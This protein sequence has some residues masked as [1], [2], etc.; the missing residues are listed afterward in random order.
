[1]EFHGHLFGAFYFKDARWRLIKINL[2]IGGILGDEYLTMPGKIYR[3]LEK[4]KVGHRASGIVGVIK[5]KEFGLLGYFLRDTLQV[6]KKFII[7]S[8]GKIKRRAPGKDS[9]GNIGWI[10]R[11]RDKHHIARIYY[12]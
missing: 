7:R 2:A 12:T 5:I 11:L 9:A 1:M 3:G 8:Y 10:A 6:W 4:F